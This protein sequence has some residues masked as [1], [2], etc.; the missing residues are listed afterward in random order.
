VRGSPSAT[1]VFV[2]PT[3]RRAKAVRVLGS[4][5]AVTALGFLVAVA[6]VLTAAP[7]P[8]HAGG[9]KLRAHAGAVSP[10]GSATTDAYAGHDET[11]SPERS[12]HALL[13]IA[14]RHR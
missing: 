14:G 12:A 5:A 9:A 6:V 7:K 4:A 13:P 8:P 1:P 11:R 2:D 10:A 3:G